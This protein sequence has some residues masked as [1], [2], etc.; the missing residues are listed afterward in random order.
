MEQKSPK[1]LASNEDP[2]PQRPH[3]WTE[4]FFKQEDMGRRCKN[5]EV[6]TGA[7]AKILVHKAGLLET[8]QDHLEILDNACGIGAVAAAVH[9]LL[10]EETKERMQLTCGDFAAPMLKAMEERIV[11]NGWINTK[12][13]MVDAQVRFVW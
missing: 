3:G 2:K 6:I 1:S 5:A 4:S 13:K 12:A 7:F 8:S 9:E 11:E 10:E